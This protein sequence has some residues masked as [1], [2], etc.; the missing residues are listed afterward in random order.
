MFPVADTCSACVIHVVHVW[1]VSLNTIV[2]CYQAVDPNSWATVFVDVKVLLS[3]A[4]QLVSRVI[5]PLEHIPRFC[6]LSEHASCV[7]KV[8]ELFVCYRAN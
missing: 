1:S 5:C 4:N 8:Y 3:T 6:L 7:S 2:L